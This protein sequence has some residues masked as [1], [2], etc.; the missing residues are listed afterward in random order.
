LA[1][2]SHETR[3]QRPNL[4]GTRTVVE[5]AHAVLGVAAWGLTI[6]WWLAPWVSRSGVD[7]QWAAW[8]P[9]WVWLIGVGV[10]GI[11]A[12][13]VSLW[14]SPRR[15]WPVAWPLL[16]VIGPLSGFL[17]RDIGWSGEVPAPRIR[18]VFLNAQSP[19]EDDAVEVLRS[20]RALNPDLAIV[21]NPGWIAPV[22]RREPQD[23]SIQWRS[24][25]MTASREGAS[26]L[27]TI[28]ADD[29]IRVVSVG[30][31]ED[32]SL[33]LGASSLL[34]VD[35]PS[36]PVLDRERIADRLEAG[37]SKAGEGR[38]DRH[39]LVVGDFNMTPRTPALSR[40]RGT[41]SDL[42]SERGRGWTATWPR[43]RPVL[44]IDQVMGRC[45]GEIGI[46]TFDPGI[47]GHRGFVIDAGGERRPDP[48]S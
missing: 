26:S 39:E 2:T 48:T 28:V 47:G 45:D 37:L 40:L 30:L 22:W 27:R 7:W 24:P 31:P 43:E 16:A 11:A 35:L 42:V 38:L 14:S 32:L 25:V 21:L 33:R 18:L 5:F 4:R 13:L 46:A 44:R 41:L 1:P 17:S 12:A 15:L 34:V 3:R 10:A 9:D 19:S 36:D 20:I 29:D 8:I 6:G 23:W